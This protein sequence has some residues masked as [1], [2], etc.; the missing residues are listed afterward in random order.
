MIGVLV[1]VDGKLK[2]ATGAVF[3]FYEFKQPSEE[4][5]MTDQD[6][7]ARQGLYSPDSKY[8][9]D[10]YDY[11]KDFEK[12]MIPLPEWTDSYVVKKNQN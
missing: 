1:E 10:Q 7:Q 12:N 5:R 2:L 4:G 6:W 11:D 8:S 3:S 9:P